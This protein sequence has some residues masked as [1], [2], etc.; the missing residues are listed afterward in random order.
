MYTR[1]LKKVAG[2]PFSNLA[3]F[4]RYNY[5]SRTLSTMFV[6]ASHLTLAEL[7][8]V[9]L[10]THILIGPADVQV[11]FTPHNQP[12]CNVS[13]REHDSASSQLLPDVGAMEE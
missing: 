13:A 10:L 5:Q 2:T 7:F 1:Q 8:G 9:N 3:G 12:V 6:C 11:K 4:S